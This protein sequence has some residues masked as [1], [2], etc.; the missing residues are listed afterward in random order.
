VPQPIIKID[1]RS[2]AKWAGRMRGKRQ[3]VKPVAA[4]TLNYLGAKA[5][6]AMTVRVA[7]Q[8]GMPEEIVRRSFV[9]TPASA[10]SLKF[11]IDAKKSMT[12]E[13][14]RRPMQSRDQLGR[15]KKRDEESFFREGELVNIVDMGDERVCP[16]CEA[17][18]ED[19]P[20]SIEEARRM[21]PLHPNCRCVVSPMEDRRRVAPV[22]A[23]Q[24][25]TSF[26]AST[27]TI[28][29]M[30]EILGR[31]RS[32]LAQAMREAMRG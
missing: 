32:D 2:V 17:A 15:F 28:E 8:T 1:S 18:A 6:D 21:I 10:G 12:E 19:G 31:M 13:T 30:S 25:G 16:I 22:E 27:G 5:V 11:I 24:T 7:A 4:A 29:P 14:A 3:R 26:Q 20:Y 9:I 23:R